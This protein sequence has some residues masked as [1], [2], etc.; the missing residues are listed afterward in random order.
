MRRKSSN[1]RRD[2]RKQSVRRATVRWQRSCL[3]EMLES[4]LALAAELV[5]PQD[6]PASEFTLRAQAGA[7]LP[8]LQLLERGTSNVVATTDFDPTVVVRSSGLADLRGDK[9]WIDTPSLVVLN[10]AMATSG[11]LLSVQFAGGMDIT[12]SLSLPLADD[13][14]H[15][16]GEG[17]Y[18]LGFSLRV[19]SSS[20]IV[21]E[22][23]S[24]TLNGSFTVISRA[25]TAGSTGSDPTKM[26]AIPS[27]SITMSSGK[28]AATNI[29]LQA[30][31]TVN[32]AIQSSDALGDVLR[33]GI[34]FSDSKANI[35]VIGTA[36]LA[37][38]GALNIDATS[39]VNASVKRQPQADSNSADD[40]YTDA[41][42][43]IV[44]VLSAAHV[45]IGGSAI[46]TANGPATIKS[47]NVAVVQSLADGLGGTS[48][49][50]GT[51]AT[52]VLGGDTTVLVDG[53]ANI[54]STGNLTIQAISNRALT[55]TSVSTPKGSKDDG[56]SS[57][58]SRGQQSLTDNDASNSDGSI[59]LAAAI[60][61]STL[62]GNT[63]ARI[64]GNNLAGPTVRSTGGT[65]RLLADATHNSIVLADG[66][67]V[68]GSN[69]GGLGVAVAVSNVDAESRASVGG[70]IHLQG[71]TITVEGKVAAGSSALDA[72]AGRKGTGVSDAEFGIAG[73][74][75]VGIHQVDALSTIEPNAQVQSAAGNQ[76]VLNAVNNTTE[77][78]RAKPLAHGSGSSLGIGGSYA[79]NVAD[80]S[81]RATIGEGA[82]LANVNHLT[83]TS[84]AVNNVTTEAKAGASG[85]VAIAGAV[86]HTVANEDTV[87]I[88]D[89]GSAIHVTG[90][91]NLTSDHRGVHSTQ[92]T[93]DSN[94]GSTAMIGGA[95]SL[96]FVDVQ[97]VATSNRNLTVT[98]ALSILANDGSSSNASAFSTSG[99]NNSDG[100]TT[101][102]QG[103]AQ[104]STGDSKANSKGARTSDS[105]TSN[106]S[107]ASSDGPVAVAAAFSLN[108]LDTFS[109]AYLPTGLHIIVGGTSTI[110]AF[111][112]TDA[113]A[114]A[115]ASAVGESSVGIGAAAAIN[116]V[117]ARIDASLASGTTLDTK[118][119]TLQSG[120]R[121]IGSDNTQSFTVD[122]VSGSGDANVGIAGSV[123]LNLIDTAT[124]AIVNGGANVVG[125]AGQPLSVTAEN[126]TSNRA[127]T[128]PRVGSSGS[129]GLGGSFT[130]NSLDHDIRAIVGDNAT[131]S[132]NPSSLT[133]DATGNHLS[134]T[135]AENGAG[136]TI[137]LGLAVGLSIIRNET[138]A[139]LGTG[140][141]LVLG[142]ATSANANVR[143]IHTSH[144]TTTAHATAAGTSVGIG[145][146]VGIADLDEIS[147]ATLARDLTLGGAMV[148]SATATN[149]STVNTTAS[150][151][152][153][154]SDAKSSDEEANHQRNSNPNVSDNSLPDISGL[155]SS[156][157]S[158]TDSQSSTGSSGVGVSASL[159]INLRN[160][161]NR[162]ALEAGADIIANGAVTIAAM[163]HFDATTKAT[164]SA[165]TIAASNNIGAGVA[166][167]VADE[168][169]ES[170][171]GANSVV[172]GSAITLQAVSPQG[173][174]L[175]FITWGAAAAGGRGNLGIAGSVAINTITLHSTATA[176]TSSSLRSS[177]NLT[178]QS[179]AR[180]NP[181]TVAAGG[182][183]SNGTTFGA[184]V[185][186]S[187][188]TPT[189][190]ASLQG[191]ADAAGV[192]LISSQMT[193]SPTKLDLPLLGQSQDPTL[194]S[195]AVAG[196]VTS[197]NTGIAG[198]VV[199]SEYSL[200]TVAFVGA[201]AQVNQSITANSNQ[202]VQIEAIDRTTLTSLAGTLSGSLS[203]IGIGAGLDLELLT[204][205]T[206][207]YVANDARVKAQNSLLIQS[208]SAEDLSSLATNAGLG[209]SVGIAGSATVTV[210]D[211]TTRAYVGD[212]STWTTAGAASVLAN[213]KFEQTGLGASAGVGGSAGFGAGNFTLLHT[214]VVQAY[215]GGNAMIEAN[216]GTGL[217]VKALSIEDL[218]GVSAAGAGGGTAGVAGSATVL[219]LDETT[220]AW[221]G[222]STQVTTDNGTSTGEPSIEVSALDSTVVVSVAGSLAVAGTAAVGAGADVSTLTKNTTAYIDSGAIIRAEGNI[223]VTADSLEDV[224]SVAAGLAASSSAGIAV[225]AA[226][227]ILDLSTRAF[228][229]DDPA[230]N[231][232]SAGSGQYLA[233]QN[234]KVAANDQTEI[235]KIVGV[236]SGS[237]GLGLAAAVGVS[238]S[239]K[240][241]QAFI[242][243]GAIV[244]AAGTGA[245][246][247]APTGEFL[248]G[249]GSAANSTPGV[250]LSDVSITSSG[251]SVSARGEIGTPQVNPMDVDQQGGS[252]ATDPSLTHQRTASPL[253]NSR[254]GLVVS[255]TNRDDIEV[256]TVSVGAG[257]VAIGVS[258]GVNVVDNTTESFIGAG[259]HVNQ[260][261]SGVNLSENSSV[262][263]TAGS[264]F[265]QI[266]FG[267]ALGGGL[268]A[269]SPAVGVTALNEV[270]RA[271]IGA[272]ARVTANDDIRL[273]ALGSQHVLL[274]GVGAAG[275]AFGLGGSVSVMTIEQQTSATVGNGARLTA[276]GDVVVWAK[277][278]TDV[279]VISGALG[280]GFAGIGAAVGVVT[281]HKDTLA[282]IAS[283][284]EVDAYGSGSGV[285]QVLSGDKTSDG[286]DFQRG[287][288]SGLVVQATSSE[289]FVH[290]A[291]AAGGGLVGLAGGVA[292]LVNDSN[293]W[294]TI[295]TGALI[296]QSVGFPTGLFPVI[297]GYGQP[298]QSVYVNAANLVD[299]FAFAGALAAGAVGLAGAVNVA[300]IKNDTAA[301][302]QGGAKV[303]AK[304]DVEVN[305]LGIKDLKGI[306]VGG[307]GALIG[308]AAS[309]SV[310]SI[311]APIEKNYS[312]Q[313]N[314]DETG[315]P[316]WDNATEAENGESVDGDAA[317]QAQDSTSTTAS[318]LDQ[319]PGDEGNP[320]QSSKKQVGRITNLGANKLNRPSLQKDTI[321]DAINDSDAPESGTTAQI[322]PAAEII[323]G[324]SI[325]VTSDDGLDFSQWTGALAAGLV[326]AGAGIS[327]NSIA[328]NSTARAGGILNAGGQITVISRLNTETSGDSLAGTAGLASIN[329]A[330]FIVTDR[331]VAQA[332]IDDQ[333]QV[334]SG[335]TLFVQALDQRKFNVD[336]GSFGA[337]LLAAGASFVRVAVQNPDAIETAAYVGTQ[338]MVEAGAVKLEALPNIHIDANTTGVAGGVIAATV[339]FSTVTMG[340]ESRATVGA[341]STISTSGDIE[342]T[343]KLVNDLDSSGT[344]VAVT[345][346]GAGIMFADVSAGSGNST[347]DVLAGLMNDVTIVSAGVLRIKAE[348]QDNIIASSVAGAGGLIVGVGSL[349][350]TI[351]EIVVK[352]QL[353]NNS[354][355]IVGGL[356]LFSEHT[357]DVDAFSDSVTIGVASGKGAFAD[358]INTTAAKIDIGSAV[359]VN[360]NQI[361]IR[362]NNYL[363]KNASTGG[364]SDLIIGAQHRTNVDSKTASGLSL[365]A[366]SSKTKIGTGG[367]GG[368][369]F[370]STVTIGPD[371]YL[372]AIGSQDNPS[373]FEI[374]L[375][376]AGLRRSPSQRCGDTGTPLRSA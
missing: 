334:K 83:L 1:Q 248:I 67:T 317:R 369:P 347:D 64:V 284:A 113:A 150:A 291:V 206:L 235:D 314:Y 205:D 45:R 352:T 265:N 367:P 134:D 273:H 73:S 160:S 236:L 12:S 136:G 92:A 335:G 57:T 219:V 361:D 140:T 240:T 137:G 200:S 343:A 169:N 341:G 208:E 231:V 309:V 30:T 250:A 198:S 152:G 274:V 176:A 239:T 155:M 356:G 18:S 95:I 354:E 4:R 81:T 50:G 128:K 156:G 78:S 130:L 292:V 233:L 124:T 89:T 179:H 211:T 242:G 24:P 251:T 353:G 323:A 56:N 185:S 37:A 118:G 287:T 109:T 147:S 60:G 19:E 192:T 96:A 143:A 348:S 71:S 104:R 244:F 333:A 125:L 366:L 107:A 295:Q 312:N 280:V 234:I 212:N 336:T 11:G 36:Q 168:I 329:A 220:Q 195:L 8:I 285:T 100:G 184:A 108:M 358:Q 53:T 28:I 181:Q 121:L 164:G 294:A 41:A 298:R 65:L 293:T 153:N 138:H 144:V 279:D 27:T 129:F 183:F 345:A 226:V 15:I 43:S 224:T 182:G 326:G 281:I 25:E 203:S 307:A 154:S 318:G 228:L 373:R 189:T 116:H 229:G 127:K 190:E 363:A 135:E 22:A 91:V 305:S 245:P 215:I 193:V 268:A 13:A 254:H 199:I 311:G 351:N 223:L 85:G 197:G 166:L 362:A 322:L 263:V 61:V 6:T 357:Q 180:I 319:Y 252:D 35:E 34:A 9:L 167:T 288:V 301:S 310:W 331:S 275:G 278:D 270:T 304:Q 88:V 55:T 214:D 201:S 349:A 66:T 372:K 296:N 172:Q 47:N 170:I 213:G 269:M 271:N 267:G 337:G 10:S 133:I 313:N 122:A 3:F 359:V 5:Y 360:A 299:G 253:T 16:A 355:I 52:T 232:P 117:A 204:K 20:D 146:S 112:N 374:V 151:Q 98:G 123:G 42:V 370:Q 327:V 145:A 340:M 39:N 80:H 90:N 84:T 225:D 344:G 74:F 227:H 148:V 375:V 110:R 300:T 257:S 321:N 186:I 54:T 222:R 165:V 97:T 260:P 40:A 218:L 297:N 258:A 346:L 68:T 126:R 338:A 70:Q 264:D 308:I 79:L 243:E 23:G 58:T 249:V 221:I 158:K 149:S 33:L 63:T 230:D 173:Q 178:V 157:N 241:T 162:A 330:V 282:L 44:D 38:T 302:I 316:A 325:R 48:D 194:T 237:A 364:L 315:T 202:S 175:D 111:G 17:N 332:F 272:N 207:A 247:D 262:S 376:Q 328:I 75:A 72:K 103:A 26:I 174:N 105:Q 86:A 171:V 209:N 131:I 102:Q 32:V 59:K 187:T 277:N 238:S 324:G 106:P 266:A 76:L 177:G 246:I 77:V 256:Y 261:F 320:R 365:D 196:A 141:T 371:S 51:L 142:T 2:Q 93:G 210:L 217:R 306:T 259:A 31:S 290:L 101:D 289:T 94:T 82:T 350:E 49:A 161:H 255:A 87:S 119:L 99:G 62:T 14:V 159:A 188:I 139:R 339:N 276:V 191:S 216:G 120:I 283:S 368:T 286:Q 7:P 69:D 115:D 342:L 46:L 132:G 29:T 114:S 163:G 303:R 21:I